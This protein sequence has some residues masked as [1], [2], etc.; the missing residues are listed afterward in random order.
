MEAQL[1]EPQREVETTLQVI[2][3]LGAIHPQGR[4][5]MEAGL[6]EIIQ[7]QADP[8]PLVEDHLQAAIVHQVDPPRAVHRVAHQV[9]HPADQ[10]LQI[11]DLQLVVVDS[12]RS[13]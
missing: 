13:Y 12:N 2:T 3:T 9:V 5:I 6:A 8:A 1:V 10:T 11:Q 4:Q 7:V